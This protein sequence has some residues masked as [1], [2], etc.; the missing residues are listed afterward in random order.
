MGDSPNSII[1][2]T[3]E[4]RDGGDVLNI[5]IV[6]ALRG[7]GVSTGPL[8]GNEEKM[9]NYGMSGPDN[10]P[11]QQM[12]SGDPDYHRGGPE[13]SQQDAISYLRSLYGR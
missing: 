4:L 12:D 1:Q 6:A 10:P 13:R 5:P 2:V 8:V 9:I 3:R 11:A 7:P